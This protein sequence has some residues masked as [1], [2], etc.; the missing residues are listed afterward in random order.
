MTVGPQG[1]ASLPDWPHTLQG[2]ALQGF[3]LQGYA[4]ENYANLPDW[5]NALHLGRRPVVTVTPLAAGPAGEGRSASLAGAQHVQPVLS[6][7]P[8]NRL[9]RPTWSARVRSVT[10]CRAHGI[11]KVTGKGCQHALVDAP[12]VLTGVAPAHGLLHAPLGSPL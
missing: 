9:F 7:E 2:Y 8:H 3:A 11:I 10:A 12:V 1:Y 5:R 4:L 6:K